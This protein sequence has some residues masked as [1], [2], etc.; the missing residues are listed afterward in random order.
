MPWYRRS[1]KST[2]ASAVPSAVDAALTAA[3]ANVAAMRSLTAAA[4]SMKASEATFMP[5]YTSWQ[6]EAWDYY[7]TLGEFRFAVD[8]KADMLSRL[9]LRAARITP[10]Q[11]EP[12]FDDSGRAAELVSELDMHGPGIPEMMSSFG[13]QLGVTGDSFLL[14]EDDNKEQNWRVYSADEIRRK[15][16]QYEVVTEDSTDAKVEWRPV[17]SNSLVCRVWR[18]HKRMRHMADAPARSMRGT[19]R[20]L[21]LINRKIQAQYLSRLASAGL[22]VMPL[23]VELPV[24]EEFEGEPDPFAAEWVE[25]ARTAIATPGTAAAAVPIPLRVPAEYVDKFRF[26]DFGLA[27]DDREIEKRESAIRRLAMQAD[28]PAEIL[29]GVGGMNHWGA[30]QVEE[31]A[32]K[33]HISSDAELIVGALSAGYLQPRLAAEGMSD[34][35][36]R[37]HVVWYD[38]SELILR[39][40]RSDAA[41]Q[42]Y[43][44]LELSGAA[45]RRETGFDEADAPSDEEIRTIALKKMAMDPASG[46]AALAELVD[47]QKLRDVAAPATAEEPAVDPAEETPEDGVG[48][49]G[50]PDD[51]RADGP[52]AEVAAIERAVE[53]SNARHLVSFYMGN[54][55]LYHPDV[56]RGATYSCP[57]AHASRHLRF[58]PGSGDFECWMNPMGTLSIGKSDTGGKSQW[59]MGHSR[60]FNGTRATL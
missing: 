30:W 49:D 4:L 36:L 21:D 6:T 14:G 40:D 35:E 59:V 9:R 47:D 7:D 46:M 33:T 54:M 12:E 37:T 10:G 16:G 20:E 23:E 43:D 18:P 51:V 44:R 48:S 13:T 1:P 32:I 56:C 28:V 45:L 2:T 58:A 3:A 50:P 55:T 60:A 15:S 5:Q 8:W 57:V 26:I 41:V 53:Q 39:P 24:R 11:D 52:D 38:A 27:S 34:E 42:A 25:V 19:M 22:L 17:K 29:L 31:S